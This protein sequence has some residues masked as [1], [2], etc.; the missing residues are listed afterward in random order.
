MELSGSIKQLAKDSS[1]YEKGKHNISKSETTLKNGNVEEEINQNE[2]NNPSVYYG[3]ICHCDWFN[4]QADQ[5]IAEQVKPNE[6]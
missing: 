1:D 6:E 5:S 2:Q 3:N 4:K